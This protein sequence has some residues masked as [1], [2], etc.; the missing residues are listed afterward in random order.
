MSDQPSNLQLTLQVGNAGTAGL[1]AGVKPLTTLTT[2]A[3]L[4]PGATSPGVIV[5]P[6]DFPGGKV[7]VV[8]DDDNG[9]DLFDE[10]H[11]DNNT[12]ELD[13]ASCLG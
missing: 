10:C 8:V 5:N 11:E 6:M 7:R 13:Q 3:A 4:D 9:V 12:I 1:P 2:D